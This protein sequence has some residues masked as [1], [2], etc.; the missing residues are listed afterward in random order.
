MGRLARKLKKDKSKTD[1]SFST[2]LQ[3]TAHRPLASVGGWVSANLN[4]APEDEVQLR[5]FFEKHFKPKGLTVGMIKVGWRGM[6]T[7]FNGNYETLAVE[8]AVS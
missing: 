6:A 5:E 3:F 1:E 8:V 7:G 2:S 4:Y